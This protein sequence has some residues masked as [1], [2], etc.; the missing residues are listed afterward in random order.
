MTTYLV[1]PITVGLGWLLLDE[2][3]TGLAML[4][5]LICLGGVAVSRRRD[6]RQAA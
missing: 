2:T 3:P 5:G 4:G 6:S 1:P